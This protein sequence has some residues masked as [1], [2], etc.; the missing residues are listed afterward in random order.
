MPHLP[1]LNLAS[2][3][4][5]VGSNRNRSFACRLPTACS[6]SRAAAVSPHKDPSIL[7]RP[8][9]RSGKRFS[10]RRRAFV[11]TE[12]F[13][14]CRCWFRSQELNSGG[15]LSALDDNVDKLCDGGSAAAPLQSHAASRLGSSATSAGTE[16]RH[17]DWAHLAGSPPGWRSSEGR[18]ND[19][20]A[21]LG[22]VGRTPHHHHNTTTPFTT[23]KVLRAPCSLAFSRR[24]NAKQR[25]T[26]VPETEH[27]F[28]RQILLDGRDRG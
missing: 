17:E 21:S 18:R 11:A 25:P 4:T 7:A 27:L 15:D 3:K 13:I 1:T 12:S 5:T 6:R 10:S 9:N 14:R 16:T 2:A 8:R 28:S 23:Y 22:G 19:P 20:A 26:A 24:D